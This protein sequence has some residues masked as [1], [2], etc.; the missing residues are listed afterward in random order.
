MFFYTLSL[1]LS[2][3]WGVASAR[4]VV[5]LQSSCS[6]PSW[7]LPSRIRA[8]VVWGEKKKVQQTEFGRA[9]QKVD[10]INA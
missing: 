10:I 8:N 2:F 7:G 5:D 6:I 4:S 3:D 1:A 9:G